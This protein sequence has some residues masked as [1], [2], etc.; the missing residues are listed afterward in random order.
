MAFAIAAYA[1]RPG[2]PGPRKARFRLIAI[3]CRAGLY[4]CRV[5]LKGFSIHLPPFPDFTW[6]NTIV[7][8]F[9]RTVEC[10][11]VK[12]SYSTKHMSAQSLRAFKT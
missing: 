9:E 3:L 6:R 1:S 12:S 4:T 2:H 8:Q 7:L 11:P 5:T 10:V